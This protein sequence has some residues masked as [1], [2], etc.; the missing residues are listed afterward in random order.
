MGNH[1]WM[2]KK[3]RRKGPNPRAAATVKTQGREEDKVHWTP[4]FT[5]GKVHIYVCDTEKAKRDAKVPTRLNNGADLAKFIRNVLPGILDQ[6]KQQ[7]GWCCQPHTV[8][9]DKASYFVAPRSQRL[10]MSF[11]DALRDA[12]LRSWLGDA[13]ADCSWL[14]GRLG[15]VFPHE[16]VIAHVRRGLDQ[17]YPRMTPGETVAQFTRRMS[18][19]QDH[20]NSDELAATDGGWVGFGGAVSS[21]EM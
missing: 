5:R 15:D 1:K 3:S 2:S 8:V 7:H 21:T 13:D 9:H 14:A 6:M 20:M 16:T 17:R 18:L 4:V 19:V 11:A 12:K 10:A